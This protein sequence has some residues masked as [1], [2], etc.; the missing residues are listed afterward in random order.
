MSI[1]VKARFPPTLLCQPSILMSGSE[2]ATFPNHALC[3]KGG[4]EIP[5]RSPNGLSA[6]HPVSVAYR[7]SSRRSAPPLT[8]AYI[9]PTPLMCEHSFHTQP[10]NVH[11]NA[12]IQ[13]SRQGGG[14]ERVAVHESRTMHAVVTPPNTRASQMSFQPIAKA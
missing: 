7:R 4:C 12:R 5:M 11:N 8:R 14:A 1:H 2:V 6:Y 10:C 9:V 13:S 3:S